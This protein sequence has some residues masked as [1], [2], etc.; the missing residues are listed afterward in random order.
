MLKKIPLNE[1]ANCKQRQ[2]NERA[3]C[4]QR[5]TLKFEVFLGFHKP[6]SK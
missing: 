2:I 6:K 1:R 4:K 3:N 5:Q